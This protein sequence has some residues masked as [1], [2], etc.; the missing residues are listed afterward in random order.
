MPRRNQA[1]GRS[2]PSTRASKYSPLWKLGL[3]DKTI[4]LSQ[5]GKYNLPLILTGSG[6]NEVISLFKQLQF[7]GGP[8]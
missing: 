2:I 8:F 6:L 3:T 5:G 7:R 4:L 1:L